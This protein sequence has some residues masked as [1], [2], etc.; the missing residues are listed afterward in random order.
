MT[1]IAPEATAEAA[2]AAPA[3]TP[4]FVQAAPPP[5]WASSEFISTMAVHVLNL[6]AVLLDLVHVDWHKGLSSLQGII[7]IAALLISSVLQAAYQNHRT[8]LKIAHVTETAKVKLEQIK[9]V[10]TAVVP[11]IPPALEAVAEGLV[12]DPE[13]KARLTSIEDALTRLQAAWA[14]PTTIVNNVGQDVTAA[15][16]VQPDQ[17]DLVAADPTVP[18]APVVPGNELPDPSAAGYDPTAS[19]G[20]PTTPATSDPTAGG[21]YLT[22]DVS[23]VAVDSGPMLAPNAV[24]DSTNGHD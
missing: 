18:V 1:A 7:P 8:Q 24:E 6:L 22:E 5:G 11:T 9:A 23:P 19:T 2:I 21:L 17:Q 10:A 20:D 3:A 16:T 14:A 12:T 13:V 4:P 15:P